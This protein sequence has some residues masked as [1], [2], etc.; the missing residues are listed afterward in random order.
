M[1]EQ[2]IEGTPAALSAKHYT[3]KMTVIK[4]EDAYIDI[5]ISTKVRQIGKTTICELIKKTLLDNGYTNVSFVSKGKTTIVSKSVSEKT[6]NIFKDI[7]IRV[8]D[9]N[10]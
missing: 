8:V 7:L 9:E 3:D 1:L 5:C 10:A 2:V 6:N 4:P